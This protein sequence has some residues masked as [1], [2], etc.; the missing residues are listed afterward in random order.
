[1][2]T[3]L[4]IANYFAR[5]EV[6]RDILMSLT[7]GFVASHFS[8]KRLLE[9][10]LAHPAFNLRTPEEGCG[11]AP[12]ELPNVF[13]PWTTAESD[14]GKRGNSPAD[15]IFSISS[16]PLRRALHRAM[17]WPFASEYPDDEPEEQT[18]QI[19]IGYFEKDA[20]PGFRGLDF[21]GR[22]TWEQAYAKC[23]PLA[24]PDFVDRIVEKA[25]VTPGATVGDGIVALKDRLVGEP[26]IEDSSEKP[27]LE[28]LV[29]TKLDDTSVA[30]LEPALRAVCGVLVS[31]PMFML[32]GIAP[33]DTRV[34]PELTPD[35]V[36]YSATC[37]AIAADLAG[38]YDV[39][40]GDGTTSA[41]KP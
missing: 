12:Y 18:F 34:V 36:S 5:T 28:A 39:T 15:G 30:S 20:E 35:D 2:G 21:Q 41:K 6:Q 14:L 17:Q 13:D 9:N 10:I 1:M 33:K 4:T 40:C 27:E 31:T 22:L 19:A 25:N 24:S 3:R 32:G 37:Q 16:R 38:R 29:K 8:L 26:W 11:A 23:T 7:E